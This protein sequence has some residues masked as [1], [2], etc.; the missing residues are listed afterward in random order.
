MQTSSLLEK[1]LPRDKKVKAFLVHVISS[2]LNSMP[3]HLA[4]K[5]WIALLIIEKIQ[6]LFKYFDFLDVFLEKKAL[7]LLEVIKTIQHVIKLQKG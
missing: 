3:I 4:Y 7:I 2:N 1:N 6:I 5:V